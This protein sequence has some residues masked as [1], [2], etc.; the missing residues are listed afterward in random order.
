M[1]VKKAPGVPCSL[2]AGSAGGRAELET[3]GRVVLTLH[4]VFLSRD[5]HCD[6][7]TASEVLFLGKCWYCVGDLIYFDA[8][9]VR[10]TAATLGEEEGGRGQCGRPRVTSPQLLPEA[11]V[12]TT[13][14]PCSVL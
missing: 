11:H 1:F 2:R 3:H 14:A 13:V 4:L 9:K 10:H 7:S 6:P 5:V 12:G 8:V